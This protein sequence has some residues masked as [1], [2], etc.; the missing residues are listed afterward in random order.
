MGLFYILALIKEGSDE[1]F[2]RAGACLVAGI[3]FEKICG[4]LGG[5]L[6]YLQ[7]NSRAADRILRHYVWVSSWGHPSHPAIDCF[8]LFAYYWVDKAKARNRLEDIKQLHTFAAD[9]Q[10]T[11]F[12]GELEGLIQSLSGP[13]PQTG[14]K[15]NPSVLVGLI[16][17]S[18]IWEHTLNALLAL[19]PETPPAKPRGEKQEQESDQRMAWFLDYVNNGECTILKKG[20]GQFTF[21]L[22]PRPRRHFKAEHVVVEETPTRIKLVSLDAKYHAIA[23]ILGKEASFPISAKD[24]IVQVM[25]ALAGDI[26]IHSD[27]EGGSDTVSEAKADSTLHV[28][29]SPLGQGLKLSMVV[30]PLGEEGPAY[31]PG[32]KGKNVIAQVNGIQMK[33]TRDLNIEKELAARLIDGCPTLATA[34]ENQGKWHFPG[35]EESLELLQ[36]L[37]RQEEADG[38]VLEWPEGK[39][40][41]L[42][43]NVSFTN[44]R[45]NSLN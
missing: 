33:T 34:E 44:C 2:S 38:I 39:P 25:D 21:V 13:E 37:E 32:S 5:L 9:R 41:E 17:E 24:K 4:L 28:Q 15:Q 1:S 29:L 3:D 22:S 27:I 16:N 20:K 11:W 23:D 35:V 18:K 19:N 14:K 43:G 42:L 45:V 26:T 8:T 7:G 10:Y 36:E 6:G 40:F 30:R 12:A 31:S